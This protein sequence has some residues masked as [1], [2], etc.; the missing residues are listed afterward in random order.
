MKSEKTPRKH[1]RQFNGCVEI[2]PPKPLFIEFIDAQRIWAFPIEHL[3][4]LVLQ[5]NLRHL[6]RKSLP[7]D[8][9][10]LVYYPA[11]VVLH[12]WRLEL[13]LTPL[14]SGRVA[15]IHAE[16]HLGA[17]IIEE[18]WVAEIQVM[19]HEK[20]VLKPEANSKLPKE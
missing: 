7:P 5:E 19:P 8:E 11:L 16:K 9:L 1:K 12:G 6:D 10:V 14:L 18:A 17:L 2:I 3:T 13:L 4:H 15:R 20:Q